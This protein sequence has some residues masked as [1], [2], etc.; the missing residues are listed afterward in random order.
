VFVAIEYAA[1][2]LFDRVRLIAAGLII[3]A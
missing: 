3:D 1:I 2:E